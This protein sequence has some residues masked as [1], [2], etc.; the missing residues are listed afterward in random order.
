MGGPG[1][2]PQIVKEPPAQNIS[3]EFNEVVLESNEI[4]L[5]ELQQ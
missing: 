2:G 4:D 3:L 5:E 1:Q